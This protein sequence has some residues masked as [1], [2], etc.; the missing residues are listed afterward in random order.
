MN[1]AKCYVCRKSAD[2]EGLVAIQVVS[3]YS[4]TPI[5]ELIQNLLA[6]YE[7]LRFEASDSICSRCLHK[8]NQYDLA[9]ITV[10]RV[11]AELRNALLS[12]HIALKQEPTNDSNFADKVKESV[13]ENDSIIG[14][15]RYRASGGALPYTSSHMFIYIIYIL[16]RYQQEYD[17]ELVK[18]EGIERVKDEN[19][20][21]DEQIEYLDVIEVEDSGDELLEIKSASKGFEEDHRLQESM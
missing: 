7:P 20:S 5:S 17:I 8:F 14:F 12:A 6:A 15:E 18:V 9:R 13:K 10:Q 2:C 4:Q 16:F 1:T 19:V 21:E 3:K 11:E